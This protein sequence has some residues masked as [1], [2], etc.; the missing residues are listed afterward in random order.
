MI[1]SWCRASTA[2]PSHLARKLTVEGEPGAVLLGPGNG[3]RGQGHA[4][5]AP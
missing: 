5:P 4:L 1:G 3:Q 2:A